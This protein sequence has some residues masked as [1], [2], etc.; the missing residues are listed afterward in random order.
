MT[1]NSPA[2]AKRRF[3]YVLLDCDGTLL[4][5][6]SDLAAAGNHVCAEHGWPTFSLDDYKHKLG[7]G[8]R[9][10]ASRIVP[11]ELAGNEALVDEV[12]QE[13]CAYYALHKEDR[14]A[15]YPGMVAALERMAEAGVVLG[16]LTNKDQGPAEMLIAQYFGGL[17]PQ[18]QGRVDGV[19]SKPEPPMTLALMERLGAAPE[20]TLMVGDTPVD[21]ACGKNVGIATCGV[22]W[23]F[24]D[25]AELKAAGADVI[26]ET[27]AE[28]AG[29]VLG[30]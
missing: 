1:A 16:A 11:P 23:G 9:V 10:L 17:L 27:P 29:W 25:R 8:Q 5:T 7:N 30:E 26:V 3:D 19:P 28:L 13:F 2:P 20:R 22:L 14:T 12:Y 15:P 6:L 4:D 18:V 24:R 21:I